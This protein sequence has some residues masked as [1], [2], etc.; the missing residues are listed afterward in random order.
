MAPSPPRT[1]RSSH[2]DPQVAPPAEGRAKSARGPIAPRG[3]AIP[4]AD[5]PEAAAEDLT[6]LRDEELLRRYRDTRQAGAFEELIRRY[7]GELH[8][9]LARYLGD[10]TLADDV[11]QNTF[12]QIYAKI[13][14]YQDGRPARP[15]IYAIATHQAIDALRRAGRRA[16]ISLD[17][18]A[19]AG[20]GIEP[21]ALIDMLAA[22][23]AGPLEGVEEAERRRWVRDSVARLPEPL[24]QT[25]ILAYYQG[26]KYR[27]IAEVLD[28]PIGTIKSRLHLAI[29]RLRQMAQ[30]AHLSR[31]G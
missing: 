15:W 11:V 2:P 5:A 13:R 28:V 3:R 14:L 27:E 23:E 8:R 29:A 10:R 6:R 19:E 12:L 31:S 16:A 7:A 30:E 26:L 17:K 21:G 4:R 1:D 25:L 22:E 18:R 24:R 9:Y 20:E